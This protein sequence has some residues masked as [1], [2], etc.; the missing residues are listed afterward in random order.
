MSNISME[1]HFAVSTGLLFFL[2]VIALYDLA[3]KKMFVSKN[4]LII[5][6]LLTSLLACSFIFRFSVCK[7]I[8]TLT[9]MGYNLLN[10]TFFGL[11]VSFVVSLLFKLRHL[12]L[13]LCPL[14]LVI[15]TAGF[16]KSLNTIPH[17][18]PNYTILT[19][20]HITFFTC[21]IIFNLISLVFFASERYL[22]KSLRKKIWGKIGY[23]HESIEKMGN[24]GF[25]F[26]IITF[27]MFGLGFLTGVYRI[28]ET[29]QFQYLADPL[30][31]GG[32]LSAFLLF[33]TY[34]FRT[35]ETKLL[36]NFTSTLSSNIIVGLSYFLTLFLNLKTHN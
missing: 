10:I 20:I 13:L 31:I 21:G 12:F 34:I 7:H 29:R 2:S 11:I 24:L 4:F 25:I 14:F 3:M 30:S 33:I 27:L 6:E 26:L 36:S 5:L 1:L 35:Y 22:Y 17:K 15:F 18:L 32:A 28:I 8:C 16:I 9:N 23:I 19:Y